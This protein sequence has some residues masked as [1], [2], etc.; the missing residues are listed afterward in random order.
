MSPKKKKANK[1]AR[2]TEEEKLRYLQHKAAM[3]EEA[4]RRK[5]ELIVTFLKVGGPIYP[6]KMSHSKFRNHR[7][8]IFIVD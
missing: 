1:L 5:Q 4:Q 2:M 6:L 7:F 3:E 8:Q